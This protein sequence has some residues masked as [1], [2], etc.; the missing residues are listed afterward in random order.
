MGAKLEKPAVPGTGGSKKIHEVGKDAKKF[1]KQNGFNS[2]ICFLVDMSLPSGENR[3]F[4]YDMSEEKVVNAAPVA[5][6]S[7]Y[8]YFLEGRRYSNAVGSGCTSLGR[9]K[10][11][12]P[13]YGTFGYSYKL[14]GLDSTNSHAYER[15]VVLHSYRSVPDTAVNREIWQSAGCPTVGTKFLQQLKG[16]I[17]H[18][19]RPILLWIYG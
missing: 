13:Y 11:G 5:H 8:E 6:G 9:Y 14:Y 2:N 18:S 7:C 12:K 17:N 16:I 1:V 15:T 19:S 10:I 4:I 3:F